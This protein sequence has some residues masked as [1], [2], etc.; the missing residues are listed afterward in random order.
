M[1]EPGVGRWGED[2]EIPLIVVSLVAVTVVNVL[3]APQETAELH[4][5]TARCIR[6]RP[7]LSARGC[8]GMTTASYWPYFTALRLPGS[9]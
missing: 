7:P 3:I 8:S 1:V 2:L 6:T 5:T 4:L 9:T